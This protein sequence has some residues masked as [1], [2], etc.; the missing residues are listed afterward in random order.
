M[1]SS[2][3]AFASKSADAHDDIFLSLDSP[4][5]VMYTAY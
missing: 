3:D 4:T 5:G 1:H 2:H